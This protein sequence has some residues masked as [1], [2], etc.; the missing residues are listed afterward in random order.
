MNKFSDKT[1]AGVAYNQY[2]RAQV[3]EVGRRPFFYNGVQIRID[4]AVNGYGINRH[5]DLEQMFQT[6]KRDGFTVVNVQ[7]RWMDI[8]PDREIA[9]CRMEGDR[10][11]F[12]VTGLGRVKAAKIRIYAEPQTKEPLQLSAYRWVN[13]SRGRLLGQTDLQSDPLGGKG[14][15]DA[16]YF[17]IYLNGA[18][19]ENADILELCLEAEDARGQRKNGHISGLSEKN[20]PKLIISPEEGTDYRYLDEIVGMAAR[21]GL[22]LEILW[23]GTDTCSLTTDSRVPCYV[24]DNYQKYVDRQGIPFLLK[25]PAENLTGVYQYLMCKND[26]ALRREEYRAVRNMFDHIAGL[27]DGGTVVGCQVANEPC[28]GKLWGSWPKDTEGAESHRC[29]CPRCQQK[30]EAMGRREQDFLDETMWG[31]TNNL[32]AAVKESAH[33]VWTRINNVLCTDAKGVDRNEWAR[34]KGESSID[35]IGSDP[36]RCNA[37]YLFRMGHENGSMKCLSPKDVYE[38][39]YAKGQNLPMVMENGGSFSG[40][41]VLTGGE[42]ASKKDDKRNYGPVHQQLLASLAGGSFYNVYD[43]CSP[44]NCGLYDFLPEGQCSPGQQGAVRLSNGWMVPHGDYVE[45]LRRTNRMLEQIGTELAAFAPDS[46]GGR[47]LVFWNGTGERYCR[48]Q[49]FLGDLELEYETDH[50]GTGIAVYRESGE[51][52]LEST[53]QAAFTIRGIDRYLE[54]EAGKPGELLTG[55]AWLAAENGCLRIEME[56]FGIRRICP[57]R[58]LKFPAPPRMRFQM[59]RLPVYTALGGRIDF[60]LDVRAD[61]GAWLRFAPLSGDDAITFT[62]TVPENFPKKAKAFLGLRLMPD[63]ANAGLRMNGKD[64]SYKVSCRGEDRFGETELSLELLPGRDNHLTFR[65][66]GGVIGLDYLELRV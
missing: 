20:A 23:F 19:E 16:N 34:S 55:E 57:S 10:I 6:A 53:E 65:P 51:L 39:I 41:W 9:A 58:A 18:P 63:G 61:V 7:I 3:L 44:D 52:I 22:K 36:Y 35:F 21:A 62:F 30:Y 27:P 12:P 43:L 38:Y 26:M 33:P 11:T 4:K 5:S 45:K 56:A 66:D 14:Q 25:G 32:A 29:K 2:D 40:E 28:V 17:D 60:P 8:Q 50:W 24:L 64:L 49:K 13:G 46:T 42:D 1:A 15:K 48:E 31:Y 47:K 37:D 59:E 54:R